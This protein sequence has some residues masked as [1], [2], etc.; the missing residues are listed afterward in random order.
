MLQQHCGTKLVCAWS[1]TI[2]GALQVPVQWPAGAME[3]AYQRCGI[4]TQDYAKTFYLVSCNAATV[5]QPGAA[6]VLN[7]LACRAPS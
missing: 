4:I 3:E 6:L 5:T 7:C 1:L 2:W